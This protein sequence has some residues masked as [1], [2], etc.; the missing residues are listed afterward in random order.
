M[1]DTCYLT[2]FFLLSLLYFISNLIRTIFSQSY[3]YLSHK[4]IPPSVNDDDDDVDSCER[5]TL[6]VCDFPV[7]IIVVT[8]VKEIERIYFFI[9]LFA[10]KKT[11]KSLLN[12]CGSDINTV[13]MYYYLIILLVAVFFLENQ[14]QVSLEKK[15]SISQLQWEKF[16]F[17]IYTVLLVN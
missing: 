9:S 15:E 5:I 2:Y 7:I 16:C 8:I 6:C 1:V 13:V 4:S 12:N 17:L 11:L 3:D 14:L 10:R